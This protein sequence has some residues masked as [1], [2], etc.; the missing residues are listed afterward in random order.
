MIF[1][2]SRYRHDRGGTKMFCGYMGSPCRSR[3]EAE[4]K[5]IET[6]KT[7]GIAGHYFE[8]SEDIE[9]YKNVTELLDK[10]NDALPSRED[11]K[12]IVREVLREQGF[13]RTLFRRI[14]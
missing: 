4:K 6:R 5:L 14:K 3:E 8:V 11:L 1:R 7:L 12:A 13:W 2:I 10:V 9:L